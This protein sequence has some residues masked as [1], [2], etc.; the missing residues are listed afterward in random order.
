M[1]LIIACVAFIIFGIIWA[2]Y[3][4]S[5]VKKM[6]YGLSLIVV[7]LLTSVLSISGIYFSNLETKGYLESFYLSNSVSYQVAVD[8]TASYLSEEE[9][10]NKLVAG[11]IEKLQLATSISDRIAEWRNS[12]VAYNQQLKK[13][14]LF[15]DNIVF[16]LFM[17]SLDSE[18][19]PIVIQ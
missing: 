3:E 17:P 10:T 19:R 13:Y 15:N 7:V 11:N 16:G 6:Y 12:V 18:I 8:K 5:K 9:F 2:I 14:Q 4:S 1:L